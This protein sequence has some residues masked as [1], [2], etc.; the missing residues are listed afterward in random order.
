MATKRLYVLS[1]I[2]V[3]V[4][5]VPLAASPTLYSGSLSVGGGGLVANAL[6]NNPTTTL[7]WSV[8]NITTPGLWHYEYHFVVPERNI[9]HMLIEV[10][11]D[12]PGPAFTSANLFNLNTDPADFLGPVAIQLWTAQQGNTGIP[13]PMY[14]IKINQNVGYTDVTVGFDSNRLPVW[15]DFYSKNGNLPGQIVIYAYNSGFSLNDP[16]VAPHDGSEQGHLLVPDSLIP[17]PGAVLLGSIGVG[18]VGWLRRRR[19]V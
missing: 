7:S 6:W 5:I 17:A 12:D 16:T 4:S 10:S 8:D 13:G 11:D 15:G 9:S 14:G 1:A 18:F 19:V 2:L 3:G